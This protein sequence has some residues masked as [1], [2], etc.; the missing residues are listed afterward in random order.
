LIERPRP[1]HP[2]LPDGW[3]PAQA[4]AAFQMLD[5]LRDQLWFAYGPAIQHALRAERQPRHQPGSRSRDR[6]QLALP[7]DSDPPF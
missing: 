3:T 6:R 5:L 1:L 4:L 2:L 7:F